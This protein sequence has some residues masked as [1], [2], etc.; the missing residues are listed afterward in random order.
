MDTKTWGRPIPIK[1]GE[2]RETITLVG[3]APP[4]FDGP[5]VLYAGMSDGPALI[6]PKITHPEHPWHHIYLIASFNEDE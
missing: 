5:G 4:R 6:P 3:K 2:R 1:S